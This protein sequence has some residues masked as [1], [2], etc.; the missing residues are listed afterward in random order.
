MEDKDDPVT[1]CTSE[2]AAP[3]PTDLP[4]TDTR[5]TLAC[6]PARRVH[7]LTPLQLAKKRA[8]DRLAQ[9]M[10]A[11]ADAHLSILLSYAENH[12]RQYDDAAS[13]AN[14]FP[15]G[16]SEHRHEDTPPELTSSSNYD[17][18]QQGYKT[19]CCRLLSP[20]SGPS[21][22]FSSSMPLPRPGMAHSEAM[23]AM[24]LNHTAPTCDFDIIVLDFISNRRVGVVKHSFR[25]KRADSSC[26]QI[27]SLLSPANESSIPSIAKVFEKIL[28]SI[29]GANQ[30]LP[31]P[32]QV[33]IFHVIFLLLR[34]QIHP[35]EENYNRMPSWLI[36][37]QSQLLTPHPAWVDYL[38][39]PSMPM[40]TILSE[41]ELLG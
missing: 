19:I 16:T 22:N 29:P 35:T 4:L 34:Y 15:H 3:K 5:P 24:P 12:L 21:R 7:G 6:V 23:F 40:P 28:G 1:T 31:L 36:P 18:R 20:T 39:W 32:E 14:P 13:N 8:N 2:A 30:R 38:P 41:R 33:A 26:L 9:Q 11:S 10:L 17:C 25:K 27:S 37:S